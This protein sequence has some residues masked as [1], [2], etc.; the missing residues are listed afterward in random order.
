[1][2]YSDNGLDDFEDDGDYDDLFWDDYD[3]YDDEEEEEPPAY[4]V[5]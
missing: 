1:M 4:L 2:A 5:D 3:V